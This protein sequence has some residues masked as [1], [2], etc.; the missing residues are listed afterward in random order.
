MKPSR[1]T[2][3]WPL[4][5]YCVGLRPSVTWKK[6]APLTARSIALPVVLML[7]CVNCCATAATLTPMPMLLVPAPFSAVAYMSPNSTRAIFAP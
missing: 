2:L 4:R 6:P 5:E 1:S 7:P 3:N